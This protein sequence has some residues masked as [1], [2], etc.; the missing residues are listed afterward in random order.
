MPTQEHP[1]PQ[2][3]QFLTDDSPHAR[4]FS[5]DLPQPSTIHARLYVPPPT[6]PPTHPFAQTGIHT[7]DSSNDAPL[8]LSRER[9][10]G[11]DPFLGKIATKRKRR[12]RGPK[13]WEYLARLLNDP[14]TNPSLVRW[15]NRSNG[16]FRLVQPAIV[17]QRW[18]RR[19]G[20]HAN[21]ALTYENFA[22]GLRYHYATGA[23]QPVSE[24]SFVYRF[25]PK[26][27][28]SLQENTPP[29]LILDTASL[30][31]Q[32]PETQSSSHSLPTVLTSVSSPPTVVTTTYYPPTTLAPASHT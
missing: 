14:S 27:L 17:A 11:R 4:S 1:I 2:T 20:K 10:R 26:A 5:K 15:E 29:A 18:G 30:S 13:C 32:Q 25:G 8:N 6:C 19:A 31:S 7:S 12:L 23:L 22:R 28:K 24:R 16:V 9:R 21:D 3:T